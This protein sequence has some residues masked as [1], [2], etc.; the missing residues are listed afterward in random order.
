MVQYKGNSII[1]AKS[2]TPS[3]PDSISQS[4]DFNPYDYIS[5][6]DYAMTKRGQAEYN[7]DLARLLYLAQIHQEE[8]MNEYNTPAAQAE[9]LRAAGINPDLAGVENHPAQNVAGYNANPIDGIPNNME[10]ASGIMSIIGSVTSLVGSIIS[11]GSSMFVN[12]VGA[13]SQAVNLFESSPTDL[14]IP[15]FI[16]SS[17]LTNRQK[18]RIR[19][20]H[21]SYISSKVASSRGANETS[22]LY[23][24]KSEMYKTA[25]NPLYNQGFF[26]NPIEEQMAYANVWKPIIDAENEFMLSKLKSGISKADYDTVYYG[27][28]NGQNDR[29][30]TNKQ[31]DFKKAQ[32]EL[33]QYLRG[34]INET[35]SELKK[36]DDKYPWAVYARGAITAFFLSKFGGIE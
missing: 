5:T 21:N 4:T 28:D 14:D 19:R 8:R 20:L 26:D 7:Q 13:A 31:Q 32:F 23:K 27:Y 29:N 11:G 9:R 30:F 36:L 16:S 2:N 22:D 18:Q 17:P 6:S 10:T 3:V 35:L 33:Y 12:A 34:P 1:F 15:E 24:S 25:S